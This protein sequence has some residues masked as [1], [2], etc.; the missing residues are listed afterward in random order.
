MP[1]TSVTKDPENLTMTVVADFPVP[2]R[3][4]WDAYVDPRQL[5]KF[6]GPPEFPATFMRHDA[7]AGG[8]STYVMT[9]P[10]GTT[11]GGYWEWNEVKAPE[12]DLAS[13]EVRDGFSRPDGTPSPDLPATTMNFWFESTPDGSR[14][15]TTTHF[16]SADALA[17]LLEMGM[18]DGMRAAMSQMD[19]VLADLQSFA[20]GRGT[21]LDVLSDTQI[22]IS[23]IVRG[24][25]EQVW[26]AH[27]DPDLLRQ[28]LLGPDGW[29]MTICDW[30][31][32]P[33]EAYRLGWAREDGAEAFDFGGEFREVRAPH[34]LVTTERMFGDD[35]PETLQ[36][37]TLTALDGGTLLSQVHTYADL[38]ARDQAVG[39]GM[40][41]GMEP[42]YERLEK[43]LAASA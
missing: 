5:E 1:I 25:V 30:T 19:D 10:D 2:L 41:D 27:T 33:G 28:W 4:L 11:H 12:G 39:S 18:E 24:S 6:W 9:G 15:T 20:A 34:R 8:V 42:T 36:V 32:T 38:A 7:F 43:V 14:V 3:R 17:Q 22:R 35:G 13:F 40:V 31:V 21:S 29:V 37:I 26:R 16:P 23:R